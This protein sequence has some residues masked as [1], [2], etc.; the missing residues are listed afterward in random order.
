MQPWQRFGRRR[1]AQS[2]WNCEP[3][4]IAAADREA[5]EAARQRQARVEQALIAEVAAEAIPPRYGKASPLRCASGWMRADLRRRSGRRSSCTMPGWKPPS[6]GLPAARRSR[7]PPRCRP[8][9]LRHQAQFMRPEQRLTR[10]LLLTVDG[11]EQAVYSR[12]RALHGQI[13]A[14]REAFAPLAQRHSHCPSALD[15]GRLGWIGR[16]CS[17]RSWR[18]PCLR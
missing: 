8:R 14:S 9:Y 5:F 6:P 13:A 1:L 2:R 4:A 18:R 15:G 12:I 3:A 17:I 16:G 10:H 11:D 7:I